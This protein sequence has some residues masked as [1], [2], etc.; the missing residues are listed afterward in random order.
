ML[1]VIALLVIGPERLPKA[2]HT[3]GLW[4]G[5][6]RG[7][8]TNVRD[9]IAREVKAENLKQIL[10]E[11]EKSSG[12]HEIIDETSSA[13]EDLN[14]P[15]DINNLDEVDKKAANESDSSPDDG[16]SQSASTQPD[17]KTTTG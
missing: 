14:R 8:Y 11:Q 2:A 17:D 9:E 7:F 15:L 12:L 1:G 13:L 5:K 10:E 3:A 16:T 4:F 6:I